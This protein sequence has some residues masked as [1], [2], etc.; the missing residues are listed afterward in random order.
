M[1]RA[2]DAYI[3]AVRRQ[4]ARSED[5]ADSFA[6]TDP[7]AEERALEAWERSQGQFDQDGAQWERAVIAACRASGVKIPRIVRKQFISNGS[8]TA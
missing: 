7:A 2:N 1:R 6:G 4:A 8:R 5:L 3:A